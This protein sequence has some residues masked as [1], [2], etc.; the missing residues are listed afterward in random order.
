[1]EEANETI[2]AFETLM[3]MY[4]DQ[5]SGWEIFLMFFNFVASMVIVFLAYWRHSDLENQKIGFKTKWEY[6]CVKASMVLIMI[7]ALFHSI[8]I[9]V[10]SMREAATY[11]GI[12]L[13]LLM[14]R[15]KQIRDK[16]NELP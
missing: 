6:H 9:E 15:I 16:R 11:S 3:G 13:Y 14:R 7:G 2:S 5:R 10:P 12:L 8:R 4:L 1:M